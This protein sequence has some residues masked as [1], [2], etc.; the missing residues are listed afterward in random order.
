MAT[1]SRCQLY[2]TSNP[3]TFTTEELQSIWEYHSKIRADIQ[4]STKLSNDMFHLCH[5]A[6]IRKFVCEQ[7]LQERT[8]MNLLVKALINDDNLTDLD[9]R[10]H[11]DIEVLSHKLARMSFIRELLLIATSGKCNPK[12][13]S[14]ALCKTLIQ[15]I[16]REHCK[17][18]SVHTVELAIIELIALGVP[19]NHIDYRGDSA[20]TT[21][22]ALAAIGIDNNYSTLQILI[23]LGSNVNHISKSVLPTALH[24]LSFSKPT[25][26]NYQA[27]ENLL[28]QGASPDA[29]TK[30]NESPI[31]LSTLMQK[32][33][34]TKLLLRYSRTL[35]KNTLNNISKL[36]DY[37]LLHFIFIGG[38]WT[39]EIKR[40]FFPEKIKTYT[41]ISPHQ[42]EC[43]SSLLYYL[44]NPLTLLETCRKQIRKHT[45][46]EQLHLLQIPKS[47]ITYLKLE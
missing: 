28:K 22:A 24:W 6:S 26:G 16:I 46:Q 17:H 47:L 35:Q 18:I 45:K 30:E 39:F 41:D 33:T 42:L 27:M 19:I 9:K 37:D 4:P 31:F 40:Y 34:H 29:L 32:N 7:T 3:E 15:S 20:L 43:H 36:G 14:I 23:K 11:Y 12:I 8:Y 38:I 21:A 13:L 2:P 25:K 44:T 10:C 5:R 1:R